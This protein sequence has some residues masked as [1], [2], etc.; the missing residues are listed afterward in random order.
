MSFLFQGNHQVVEMCYQR[1]KN[2]D[3]LS[4]LYLITGNLDKLRKMTKIAEIRKDV[5]SQFL[6][7]LY[8]GDVEERVKLLKSCDQTLLAYLTAATHGLKEEAINLVENCGQNPPKVNPKAVLLRPP[9]PINQA[10]TNWPLLTVSKSFFDGPAVKTKYTAVAVN[11]EDEDLEVIGGEGW[12]ADLELDD[13]E[14]AQPKGSAKDIDDEAG[15]DVGDEDLELPPDLITSN[16]KDDK[17]FVCPTFG[18]P[19]YNQWVS[20]SQLPIDHIL[21]GS[22]TTAF[23]LLHDQLGIINFSPF[24]QI[25]LTSFMQSRTMYSPFPLTPPLFVY[26][27]RNLQ[28]SSRTSY[29]CVV[30]KL[31]TLIENLHASYHLTTLGKFS[32]A[33]EKFRTLLLTVPL[34]VVESKQDFLEAQQLL[35][36]CKEYVLALQME[37]TRKDLPKNTIEEQLRICELSAYFTHCNL[38]S[39]HAVLTLRT[40]VNL[41]FKM[42]NYKTAGSFAR[43]LLEVATKPEV[44]QQARKILQA[45]EK[46]P[47]DEHRIEYDERNPFNICGYAYVPIYRGKPEEKCSFCNAVYL[48]QYKGKVCNVCKVAEIGKVSSGLRIS[49]ERF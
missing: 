41:F 45:C 24:K 2:F 16:E 3:K 6:G 22:F 21:A 42:K 1:T 37:V 12:D 29:P 43:R 17:F 48:P 35:S 32:E 5:S 14:N 33:V 18:T 11:E 30:F 23:K 9:L 8:L 49:L 39:V 40:A 36:I 13:E 10:E 4:F 34:L 25:F 27:L 28:D 26:P 46:K 44:T 47:V 7:A 15:W 38:Q 19:D 20:N 31:P